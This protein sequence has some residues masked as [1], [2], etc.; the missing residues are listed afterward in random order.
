MAPVFKNISELV[1][2]LFQA[3]NASEIS[4]LRKIADKPS[5][6]V[7]VSEPT[8]LEDIGKKGLKHQLKTSSNKLAAVNPQDLPAYCQG[9]SM[10]HQEHMLNVLLLQFD[11]GA[12]H[13]D[14]AIWSPKTF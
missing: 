10:S 13:S 8:C 6:P 3:E 5:V 4:R 14:S 9:G 7:Q 2:N 11:N 1:S 12:D